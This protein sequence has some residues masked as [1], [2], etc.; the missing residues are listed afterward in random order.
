[1]LTS[2]LA[3]F[4]PFRKFPTNYTTVLFFSTGCTHLWPH[5]RKDQPAVFVMVFTD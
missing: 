1:L 4:L 2:S 3:F 5:V